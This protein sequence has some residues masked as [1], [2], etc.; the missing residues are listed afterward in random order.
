MIEDNFEKTIEKHLKIW[1]N[2]IEK[3]KWEVR[4]MPFSKYLD[5]KRDICRDLVEYLGKEYEYVSILGTDVRTQA[6]RS[7][8][9]ISMIRE[10][11]GECGFVVKLQKDGMFFEYSLDDI[12]GNAQAVAQKISDALKVD[13][14]LK[15]RTIG[16]EGIKDEPLKKD[17][18]RE[19]DFDGY[20]DSE[21]LDLCKKIRDELLQKDE[22][23]VNAIVSVQPYTVSKLFISKNRELS[24]H[25]GWANGGIYGVYFDGKMVMVRDGANSN[26]LSEVL[27]KLSGLTDQLADRAKKLVGAKPIEPGVYDVITD[28]SI[29]GLIAHEAFGHGVEMDQFVKD[30]A[31]AKKY[32]GKYVASP[33]T[34][35]RDGAAATLSAASYFFD[36]D[37][38]LAHDTQIIRNGVLVAG[39]SDLVSATELS[40]EPTGNGRRQSFKRKA[41]SRMTN[42]FFEPGSDK[43]S[44]MIGSVKHGYMLFQ[45]NNG[46]ED[47]KNWQIQCTAEYGIE[48]VDGKLTDNYVSPVVMSGFVPDLLGSISMVSDNFEVIGAGMCGK[49]YKE[50]VRVSDGGPNLKVKV[51]LG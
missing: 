40:T 24:Q 48:I 37:G 2:R 6:W 45:T 29:T 41:Y 20:T 28:S 16:A 9:N 19:S 35:M 44:D 22:H 39:L 34:N 17:F 49:G 30:R 38:V 31:L 12:S 1:Y 14:S 21:I 4:K 26:L 32:M 5:S 3:K 23:F 51:K 11:D 18:V 7:D 47:P 50:W 43:L 15:E 46:M 10:G 13:A 36:D 33:I 27:P 42:T 25:Y 8:R